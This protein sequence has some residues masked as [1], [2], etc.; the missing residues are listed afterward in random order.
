MLLL[1]FYCFKTN[2]MKRVLKCKDI[3]T[4]QLEARE[5]M[6]DE[7]NRFFKHEKNLAG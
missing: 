5:R 6:P 1:T 2:K 3:Q 7:H 4:V